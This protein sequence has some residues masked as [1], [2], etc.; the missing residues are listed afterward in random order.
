MNKAV[1]IV[2]AGGGGGLGIGRF[3]EENVQQA[4][5]IVPERGE[6]SGQVEL[7]PFERLL[8]GYGGN[9]HHFHEK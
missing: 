3:L 6:I 2:V 1:P 4:K 7:D 9:Y 5:G 8:S